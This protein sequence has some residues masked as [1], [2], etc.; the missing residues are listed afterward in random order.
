MNPAPTPG[1]RQDAQRMAGE[2]DWQM[3]KLQMIQKSSKI[4]TL[5]STVTGDFNT[6]TT[7]GKSGL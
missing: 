2:A 7:G 1:P 6:V 3:V 4:T 5:N